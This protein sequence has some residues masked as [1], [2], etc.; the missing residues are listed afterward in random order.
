MRWGVVVGRYNQ[1]SYVC[2]QREEEG[3]ILSEVSANSVKIDTY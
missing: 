3:E 1:G 2:S